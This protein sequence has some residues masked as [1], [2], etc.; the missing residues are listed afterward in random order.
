M[1]PSAF[2][3]H[4][5]DVVDGGAPVFVKRATDE[6]G[7]SRL[8]TEAVILR[9]LAH[10][11]TVSVVALVED[12]DAVELH[13]A[14]AGSH[15][16]ATITG[17][18]PRSAAEIVAGLASIVADVHA[19]GL[20][21]RRLT[22]DHV[23][24]GPGG[25]PVL[26]GFAD[27]VAVDRADR[28]D[29]VAALGALLSALVAPLPDDVVLP[30]RWWD[31]WWGRVR[32]PAAWAE[33]P[34]RDRG[35]RAVLLV[36]AD[37]AQADDLAARP[38]AGAL[39]VSLREAADIGGDQRRVGPL[40]SAPSPGGGHTREGRPQLRRHEEGRALSREARPFTLGE[41][42]VEAPA[43]ERPASSWARALGAG[44]WVVTL[45]A[46]AL[47]LHA[48]G[49]G[50]LAPPPVLDRSALER[51]LAERDALVIAFA[52]VRLAG[53][54][55]TLYLLAVTALGVVARLSRIPA[56]VAAA[57]VATVPPVRSV[58]GALAGAGLTASAASMVATNTL[59]PM[60]VPVVVPSDEAPPPISD[61]VPTDPRRVSDGEP[62]AAAEAPV[63]VEGEPGPAD[64]AI[65][66]VDDGAVSA[67]TAGR[68]AVVPGDHLWAVAETTLARAW[69][70]SPSDAEVDP[71]WR[72]V[73]EA[74][75][76]HLLD[77]ANPDLVRPGQILTV[78]IPPS[79][80][81]PGA[82]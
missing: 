57:D 72:A 63:V 56:L 70:R 40:A 26:A 69:G 18:T 37:Q 30:E 74:N 77:P 36:L 45:V 20:V 55:L 24:L 41:V 78:P 76:A 19:A 16:L 29:D 14:W 38:S 64:P 7:R 44:A 13:L 46:S 11:A 58:L 79:A 8:R 75:R 81:P 2:S 17:V 47:L 51:W 5:I 34:G 1:D 31:Q 35:L 48:L 59:A 61:P 67:S 33:R 52:L 39:A 66:E 28:G 53:F 12:T 22:P 65:V 60:T 32:S 68:W 21:H 23:V 49:S 80:P 71:Y 62:P 25:Q 3:T 42:S 9:A 15:T 27:A 6:A 54:A 10:P 73:V 4:R 50:L 82:R 43:P